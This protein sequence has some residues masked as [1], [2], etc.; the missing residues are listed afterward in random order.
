M[1][2]KPKKPLPAAQ[3]RDKKRRKAEFMVV[4]INGQQKRVRRPPTT[5][6]LSADEFIRRDADPI[7]LQQHGYWEYLDAK[8]DTPE[9]PPPR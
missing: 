4:F 6:G 2:K 7:W 1:A 9:P 3:R 8:S 5:D